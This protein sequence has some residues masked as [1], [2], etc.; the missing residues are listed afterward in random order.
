MFQGKYCT[1]EARKEAERLWKIREKDLMAMYMPE[2]LS[3]KELI[4]FLEDEGVEI[5]ERSDYDSEE[6]WR[7]AL[8]EECR[9]RVYDYG[10]SIDVVEP[11]TFKDQPDPFLRYQFSWGGGQDEI[12]FYCTPDSDIYDSAEYW[13]L[14]WG[15]GCYIDISNTPLADTIWEYLHE[16]MYEEFERIKEGGCEIYEECDPEYIPDYCKD[17][18]SLAR[19]IIEVVDEDELVEMAVYLMPSINDEIWDIIDDNEGLSEKT[20]VRIKKALERNPDAEEM[21]RILREIE[22]ENKDVYDD[23]IEVIKESLISDI[24]YNYDDAEWLYE[25]YGGR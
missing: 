6:E 22:R 14:N 16:V 4:D 15:V 9:E 18:E 19:D 7:D 17:Y 25:Q 8:E 11:C 12:R 2:E 23:I 5:P 24:E 13:Y 10:L 1:E 21:K 20:I 3:T